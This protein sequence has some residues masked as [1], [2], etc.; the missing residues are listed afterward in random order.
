MDQK[1]RVLVIDDSAFVRK[2]VTQMLES[3]PAITVVGKA[4]NGELGLELTRELNPDVVVVDLIMPIMNGVEYIRHQMNMKPLPILVLSITAENGEMALEAIDA[5][6]ISF[7]QKPTALATEKLYEITD[8]LNSTIKSLYKVE[9]KPV[10]RSTVLPKVK[11]IKKVFDNR[12][13]KYDIVLIGISTGGPQALKRLI[14][15]FS[16]DFPIPVAVVLHMP[17]GYTDMFAKRMND[18]SMLKVLESETGMCVEKGTVFIAKAGWHLKF[19]KSGNQ[20]FCLNDR[21]PLDTL[22]RPSVDVLF[23]SAAQLYGSRVLAIVMTGMGSDGLTGARSIHKAGGKIL[24]ESEDSCIVY[25]MPRSIVEAG[26]S[27]Q[28][29]NL[30]EMYHQIMENLYG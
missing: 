25:G 6:A 11:K 12:T 19:S 8:E 10:L 21:Q 16:A 3:D 27:D 13:P 9:L 14:P 17:E 2:V 29:V 5:G 7:L 28:V 4:S 30:D 18:M 23:E 1:I 26:I 22:H 20:V 24:T 15:Q